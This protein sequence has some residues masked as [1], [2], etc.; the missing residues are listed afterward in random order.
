MEGTE[1]VATVAAPR[2]HARQL[3]QAVLGDLQ[4]RLSRNAFDN[5]LRPTTIVEVS[6][7][8]ATVAAPNTFSAAT[9]QSRF[10][11]QIE[12]ALAGIVGRPIQVQFTVLGA[13]GNAVPV[14]AG[15]P[16]DEA[17]FPPGEPPPMFGDVPAPRAPGRAA[18]VSPPPT[19]RAPNAPSARTAAGASGRASAGAPAVPRPSTQLALAAAPAHGLNPRYVYE[20]YVVGSSNR[21]AHAASLSVAEQPGGKFNPFFVHGGVGLGKTH[22]LHAIGHRALGLRPDLTIAYVSSE[23]FTNDLINAIRAQRMD[24]FRARYRTID[25]LMIDDIQFIAGKEST[26][27]EFFHTFNALYQSGKQV[28]IT[29]DKPP[30]SI[31]A[32]EDRL[33]SRFEGGL[34][35][36]VQFPDYETRT[37]ILRTKGEELGVA[38]PADVVEYV[39]QKDQ[40][41]IR[42]LEGALNKILALAQITDRPLSLPLAMEALTDAAIG[43]R[44][45]KTSPAA[46]VEAVAVYYKIGVA[47]LRGRARS[48][49]IVLPRQVAMFLARQETDAS[50]VDIG[51][52]LGGRDHTTVMHGIAKI[53]RDL[54]TNAA[55]RGQ[56]MA[57]R[58]ALFGGG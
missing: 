57:V 47:A 36:D 13:V 40:S 20:S 53:E 21:F 15:E 43:T 4:V 2:M 50:L 32:L 24:E 9:L 28:I 16:E 34:I 35:A 42:E 45:V 33:R 11:P 18:P 46:V 1:Q 48:Q 39:A 54:S 27:E 14:A 37:A 41:N 25:I 51:R 56:V 55:L 52:E 17:D 5:W 49:E 29:S 7:D 26:Q 10:A 38:V 58:E 22:L 19:S 30:K 8:V 6:D 44:R 31:S 12:R 3:W 23:K